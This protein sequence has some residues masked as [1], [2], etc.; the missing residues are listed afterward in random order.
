[1]IKIP[2]DL[3]KE[4]VIDSW[5]IPFIAAGTTLRQEQEVPDPIALPF[6]KQREQHTLLPFSC[7][8]FRE[9]LLPQAS[10]E[11]LTDMPTGRLPW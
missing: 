11:T 10:L 9:S 1:M 2:D 4:R 3:R 8:T 6:R 5:K 7:P